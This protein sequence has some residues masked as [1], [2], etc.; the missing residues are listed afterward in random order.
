MKYKILLTLIIIMFFIGGAGLTYS[1]FSSN[2]ENSNID[3]KIAKF[4]FDAQTLEQIEI[5]II[6]MYPGQTEEYNFSITNTSNN[7][8]SD[9]SIEY[10]LIIKTPHYAP[11]IIELYDD[12]ENIIMSCDESYSRN[13]NNELICN[14]ETIDMN[15]ESTDV[16]NFKLKV[17]F[18]KQYNSEIYTDLIDYIN[19]EV[20]SYQKV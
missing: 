7:I 14:T 15:Y 1:Y 5:P 20:K 2:I 18:D 16:D 9:V 12:Q 17:T 11:L 8:T 19:I 10:Q 4:I 3:Q 13:E 6:N